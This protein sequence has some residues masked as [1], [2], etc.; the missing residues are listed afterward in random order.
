MVGT[1]MKIVGCSRSMVRSTSIG[2]KWGSRISSQPKRRHRF[3]TAVMPKA[4]NRGST[5]SIFSSPGLVS[6][7]HIPTCTALAYRLAWVSMAPLGRP[8][9]PPV[10]WSTAMSRAGSTATGSTAPSLS[11]RRS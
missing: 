5:P 8:V 3:I 4:W 1:P 2:L 7:P 11:I 9:V 6:G 10:Y